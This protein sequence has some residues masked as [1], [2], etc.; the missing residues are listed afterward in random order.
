MDLGLDLDAEHDEPSDVGKLHSKTTL[1]YEQVRR[2]SQSSVTALNNRSR[3]QPASTTQQT[4]LE[5]R[6]YGRETT[7]L[8]CMSLVLGYLMRSPRTHPLLQIKTAHKLWYVLVIR[9]S[10]LA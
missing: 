9:P 10:L 2:T 6:T 8:L 5:M 7:L 1:H 3:L 4:N